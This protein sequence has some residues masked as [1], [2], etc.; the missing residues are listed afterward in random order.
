MIQAKSITAHPSPFA[1]Q[2][3]VSMR[4]LAARKATVFLV[5]LAMLVCCVTAAAA[6]PIV[7][8]AHRTVTMPIAGGKV[9]GVQCRVEIANMQ[10]PGYVPVRITLASTTGTFTADRRFTV[11]IGTQERGQTPIRNGLVVDLPVVAT[12]GNR[13]VTVDRFIPKW[14]AGHAVTLKLLEDGREMPDYVGT[15]GGGLDSSVYRTVE[16]LSSEWNPNTVIVLPSGTTKDT[17]EFRASLGT[18]SGWNLPT[19]NQRS[20]DDVEFW[21]SIFGDNYVTLLTAAELSHDWRS[22][23]R[24]DVVMI[25]PA[26]IE[27]IASTDPSALD[28]IRE[29]LMLGGIVVVYRCQD[30]DAAI[31]SLDITPTRNETAARVIKAKRTQNAAQRYT[32]LTEAR[33]RLAAIDAHLE[34]L[35]ILDSADAKAMQDYLDSNSN[36]NGNGNGSDMGMSYGDQTSRS[37][38]IYNNVEYWFAETVDAAK[39]ER[40]SI[41]NEIEVHEKMIA[42]ESESTA[43]QVTQQAAGAGLLITTAG[44]LDDVDA[45][46]QWDVV[47]GLFGSRVSPILRRGVDPMLGDGRFGRWVIDGVAQPPVYTFM[48]LLTVFVILVGP[49]AYRKTSQA[50]RSYLMFAIAP[51]LALVTTAAMFTYGILSDGFGTIARVR[52][53][54]FVD[55]LSGDGVERVRASY[56]AGVRPSDGI[57]FEPDAE[58]MPYLPNNNSSWNQALSGRPGDLGRVVIDESGQRFDS[59]FLRSRE[60]TQFVTHRPRRGI[61]KLTLVLSESTT[62]LEN[63]FDF[64]LSVVVARDEGGSYHVATDVQPGKTTSMK[65]IDPRLA[66]KILGKM[67]ADDRPISSSSENRERRRNSYYGYNEVYDLILEINRNVNDTSGFTDGLFELQIQQDLQSAGELSNGH[68]AAVARTSRDALAVA[69]AQ[70]VE[71]VRYVCGSLALPNTEDKP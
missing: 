69:T 41:T 62:S 49:V 64:A 31:T 57:R 44:A 37:M 71:S 6:E 5:A 11:R 10:A 30:A 33:E 42:R 2:E 8:S 1:P 34:K 20:R 21:N 29:F 53:V 68:F 60:Q 3:C 25:D 17:A 18:N 55:G 61:G 52:Q 14:S 56:F 27:T 36:N 47:R 12:Q 58:V 19:R 35:V 43:F 9:Q 38:Q 70:P 13:S 45:I 23:N 54:T 48:G 40:D 59:S 67:Y 26:M 50:G 15:I 16:I 65:A 22:Y 51:V 4:T 24:H 63:S 46:D 39:L 32:S 7:G 66:S 28:A